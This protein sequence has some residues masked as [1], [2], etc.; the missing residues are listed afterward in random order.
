MGNANSDLFERTV[1][2]VTRMECINFICGGFVFFEVDIG[3]KK[4]AVGNLRKV[5]VSC[6]L[7]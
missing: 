6:F 5:R 2:F 7:G 4:E 1:D 3:D